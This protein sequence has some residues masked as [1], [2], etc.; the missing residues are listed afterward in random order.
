MGQ[1]T[2]PLK[3]MAGIPIRSF[4]TKNIESDLDTIRTELVREKIKE[5]KFGRHVE[6]PTGKF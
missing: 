1:N 3:Q 5:I 6:Y 4:D 2:K